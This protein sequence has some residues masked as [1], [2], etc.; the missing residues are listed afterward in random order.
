MPTFVVPKARPSDRLMRPAGTWTIVA[1]GH[2]HWGNNTLSYLYDLFAAAATARYLRGD[3][4]AHR[5]VPTWLNKGVNG[6]LIA[7]FTARVGTDVTPFAPAAVLVS[8]ASNDIG[9]G[10]TPAQYLTDIRALRDALIAAGVP[11]A[12]CGFVNLCFHGNTFP[13]AD[14]A[15]INSYNAN[16]Q[17]AADERGCCVLDVRT[18]YVARR[19][20]GLGPI[21]DDLLHPNIGS[22]PAYTNPNGDR[23]YCAWLQAASAFAA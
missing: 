3:G 16:L 15:T 7:G 18:Q 8:D 22:G 1:L 17:L 23:L 6:E 14:I 21:T 9:G 10:R 4:K 11:P 20:A 19:T 5:D 12:G 2:S 13:E